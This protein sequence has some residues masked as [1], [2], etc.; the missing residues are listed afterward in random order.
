MSWLGMSTCRVCGCTDS[1]ACV[2]ADG[3]CYWVEPGL[4]SACVDLEEVP[5]VRVF[6]EAEANEYLRQRAYV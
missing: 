6:T 5:A 3:P 4:C 2:T 1:R